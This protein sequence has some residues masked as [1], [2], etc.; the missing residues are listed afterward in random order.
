MATACWAFIVAKSTPL[1]T[2]PVLDF[3]PLQCTNMEI[4]QQLIH[5]PLWMGWGQIWTGALIARQPFKAPLS[6]RHCIEVATQS[7][8]GHVEVRGHQ[9][10]LAPSPNGN[11][12]PYM[13]STPTT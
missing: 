6:A 3:E 10:P 9:P 11:L 4:H 1:K 8:V 7:G 12:T 13:P 5:K 2:A